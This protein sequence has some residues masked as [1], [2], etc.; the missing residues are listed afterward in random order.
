[1]GINAVNLALSKSYTKKT[2]E[3]A[4]ALK[5]EDGFSP[6]V[7]INKTEDGTEVSIT[8]SAHT[9]TFEIKNGKGVPAGGKDGQ[10]LTKTGES[11]EWKDLKDASFP[12]FIQCVL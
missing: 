5:G 9:E 12:D 8:D 1:M 4:G 11:E 7:S 3:G 6:V 10:V 2:V